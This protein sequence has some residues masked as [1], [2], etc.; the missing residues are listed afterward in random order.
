MLAAAGGHAAVVQLLLDGGARM[1][2]H[3]GD[4]RTGQTALQAAE[5]GGHVA[6]ARMLRGASVTN[7]C[8]RALP[9]IGLLA[10]VL[11]AS[12][13]LLGWPRPAGWWPSQYGTSRW[14]A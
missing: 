13:S 2:S 10:G 9:K 4:L 1:H 11:W 14:I 8:L 7:R 12:A 3:I 6:V 5:A